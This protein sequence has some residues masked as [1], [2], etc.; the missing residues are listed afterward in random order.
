MRTAALIVAVF[1]TFADGVT[2]AQADE[3]K[4][5]KATEARNHVG[6]TCSITFKVRHTKHGVNRKTYFLDS[7]EDFK[8]DK[9][10][11]VQISETVAATLKEKKSVTDPHVYYADKTIRVV[12][13]IFLQEDRPYLTIEKPE[14]I[15]L[16][17]GQ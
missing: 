13:K 15:D 2:T 12:G 14:D 11:G 3:P 1:V 6:E 16:V 10:L 5:I 8:S 4:V 17:D 9:N 7:E